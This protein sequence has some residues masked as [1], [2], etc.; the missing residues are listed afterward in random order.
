MALYFKEPSDSAPSVSP[1]LDLSRMSSTSGNAD[2]S[3][4]RSIHM[5][6]SL[7]LYPPRILNQVPKPILI[8]G[9]IRRQHVL[10]TFLIPQVPMPLPNITTLNN[11]ETI[12][13]SAASLVF[14]NVKWARNV[15][16]FVNLP[17]DDQVNF[18]GDYINRVTPP[19]PKPVSILKPRRVFAA[20]FIERKL[21]RIVHV[22]S[23]AVFTAF[24]VESFG[25]GVHGTE[26]R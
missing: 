12:C 26:S 8:Y 14:M 22:G 16:A 11:P 21:A 24:G 25:D 19:S 5:S 17:V 15:P 9:H 1:G 10:I 4:D 13:E 23:S 20:D 6:N 18:D 3:L 2:E 7:F